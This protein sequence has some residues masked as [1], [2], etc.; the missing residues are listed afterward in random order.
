[1]RAMRMSDLEIADPKKENKLLM[2]DVE[3]NKTCAVSIEQLLGMQ[4]EALQKECK[5]CGNVGSYDSHGNCGCCGAPKG[6]L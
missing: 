4:Q 6:Q 3:A 5:H 2:L 1:M